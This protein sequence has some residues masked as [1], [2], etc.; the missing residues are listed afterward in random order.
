MNIF[1]KVLKI[2]SA[3]SVYVLMVFKSFE[4]LF[5]K[6]FKLSETLHIFDSENIGSRL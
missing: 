2:R 1:L 4:D 5:M 3:L 6:K